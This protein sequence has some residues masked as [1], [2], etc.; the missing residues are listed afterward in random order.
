MTEFIQW[1]LV[2]LFIVLISNAVIYEI[3]K[4]WINLF[5]KRNTRET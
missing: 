4:A 2:I 3:V 1:F 5:N